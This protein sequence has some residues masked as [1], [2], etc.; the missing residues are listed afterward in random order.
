MR[1][2]SPGDGALKYF[3]CNYGTSGLPFRGP[4]RDTSRPYLAFLGGTETFGK[5]V[6]RPFPAVVEQALGLPCVNLGW[7]NGGLDLY[8]RNPGVLGV[9]A[10]AV[11]TVVQ[12]TGAQN[13]S[14]RFY[15]VHPRRNDR[16]VKA[17]EPL[18]R[19]YADVDFTEFHFTRHL[20][21]SLRDRSADRF[22]TV[23][24][25][26]REAWTARMQE[27]LDQLPPPVILL[28]F[29]GH[30]PGE[31]GA[32][33]GGPDPLFVTRGMVEAV[34]GKA[35]RHVEVV[36]SDRARRLG[37]DGMV[38]GPA[39]AAAAQDL[40]GPAAHEEAADALAPV[41]LGLAQAAGVEV[42]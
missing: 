29:A 31:A 33:P 9:A 23:L 11:A 42:E 18:R 32:D 37:C 6:P 13:L 5:F 35:G 16:F 21:A 19:L 28:W 40:P 20:L 27:L 24:A 15:D 12:I 34:R 3:P 2:E 39:E 25:G 4:P 8:L 36:V 14:N 26:L 17:S 10:G 30:A 38:F 1:L 41:L 22:E 7:V